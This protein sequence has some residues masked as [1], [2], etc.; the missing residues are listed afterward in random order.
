MCSFDYYTVRVCQNQTH[1]S[2]RLY[3]YYL[4]SQ[5]YCLVY[6]MNSVLV[7]KIQIH[8]MSR[9]FFSVQLPLNG[10]CS[11]LTDTELTSTIGRTVDGIRHLTLSPLIWI[12]GFECF[13]RFAHLHVLVNRHL[14]VWSFELR[15]VVVDV[16]QFDDHPRVRDVVFIMVVIFALNCRT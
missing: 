2:I 12:S 8:L 10:N 14:D 11:F 16:A 13:Q 1:V 4:K 15:F 6:R 9:S 5:K 3:G 7:Y